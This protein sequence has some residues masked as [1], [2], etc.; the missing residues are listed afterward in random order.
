[1]SAV[2]LAWHHGISVERQL[3]AVLALRPASPWLQKVL[4]FSPQ[5]A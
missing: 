2:V 1:M 4:I 5:F 3:E